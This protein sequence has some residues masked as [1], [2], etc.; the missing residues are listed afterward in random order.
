MS[1]M[2]EIKDFIITRE[3][4]APIDLVWKV[5][6][7]E[8]HLG[9]MAPVGFDMKFKK[10]EFKVGGQCLCKQASTDGMD[11]WGR[12][13]IR[14]IEINKRIEFLISVSDK[15]G[16]LAEHAMVATWPKQTLSTTLFEE[17][18]GKTIVTLKWTPY[19][20]NEEALETFN[21]SIAGMTQAWNDTFDNLDTYIEKI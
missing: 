14:K 13:D 2:N 5:W 19:E 8:K 4:A 16:N 12:W 7:E 21:N 10:F 1:T 15:D 9:W 11:M 3:F 17:K 20:A 18:N 6:T